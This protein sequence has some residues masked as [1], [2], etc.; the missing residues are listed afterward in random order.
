MRE[1]VVIVPTFN[2]EKW[3]EKAVRSIFN[4]SYQ[5]VTAICVDDNSSDSTPLILNNLKNNYKKLI[6]LKNDRNMGVSF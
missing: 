3:I 4:Q 2:A 6:V 1:I 5:N